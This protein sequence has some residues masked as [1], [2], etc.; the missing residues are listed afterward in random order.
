M[1]LSLSRGSAAVVAVGFRP[2]FRDPGVARYVEPQRRRGLALAVGCSGAAAASEQSDE[3]N[4]ATL[5][6]HRSLWTCGVGHDVL[7][8]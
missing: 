5:W 7:P 8:F 6:T 1:L 4:I 2:H 3:Q